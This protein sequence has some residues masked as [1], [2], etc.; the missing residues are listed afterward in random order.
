MKHDA[1]VGY[2]AKVSCIPGIKLEYAADRIVIVR[3]I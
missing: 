1:I 3:S 2:P